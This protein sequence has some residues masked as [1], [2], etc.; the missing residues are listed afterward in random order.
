MAT[1]FEKVIEESLEEE[2]GVPFDVR[3][4]NGSPYHLV[5][6]LRSDR[7]D[8]FAVICDMPSAVRMRLRLKADDYSRPLFDTMAEATVEMRKECQRLLLAL[9]DDSYSMSLRVNGTELC[10]TACIDWPPRW[11][12][13]DYETTV[14]PLKEY[15]GIEEL[16]SI[17]RTRI[18]LM[19]AP[20]FALL[21][22]REDV[23][24]GFVEGGS[25]AVELTRYERDPRN[26]RICLEYSG[27]SC[28]ICGMDFERTYGP[29]GMGFIHVHHIV[30]VSK[31]GEGYAI[32]PK[33]DLIP[34]C[35][36]CHYMLHRTDP[37]LLPDELRSM[38]RDGHD[39]D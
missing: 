24:E 3:L 21:D 25:H 27:T 2:F 12:S 4:E 7:K 15:K 35:P 19:L 29:I 39:C 22:V 13:I 30:P 31:L 18:E 37:P 9:R 5:A 36:N 33:R 17:A 38:L 26:R 6:S 20:V 1:R 8:G 10:D 23:Q 32:D 28:S 11:Q 34:V 14:F 16:S